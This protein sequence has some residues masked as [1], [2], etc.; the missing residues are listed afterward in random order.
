MAKNENFTDFIIPLRVDDLSFSEI[1]VAIHRLNV[2]DFTHGWASG[3][4]QVLDKLEKDKVP[5]DT[6]RFNPTAVSQWWKAHCNGDDILRREPDRYLSNWFPILECPNVVYVHDLGHKHQRFER[7]HNDLL[8]P[9]YPIRDS[10]VSFATA[11]D[12][13]LTDAKTTFIP[14]EE[15]LNPVNSA[16][17]L[18]ARERQNAVTCLM[19]MAWLAWIRG[20][21]PVHSMSSDRVC[22]Y[23][24]LEKVGTQLLPFDIPDCMKGRRGLIG[25]VKGK[26]WHFGISGDF[27]LGPILAMVVR[28]HVLF[29]SDGR[30]IWPSPQALHRKRRSACKSWWNQ[31]WRDRILASMYW[32]SQKQGGAF[33]SIPLSRTSCLQVGI[34]PVSFESPVAYDDVRVMENP[35][36][37]E[38]SVDDHDED[39]E[40]A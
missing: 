35:F 18:D 21:L 32:L 24:T 28:P 40:E 16:F 2:I 15:C 6:S 37:D 9:G 34:A 12:L 3:L 26:A 25:E 5:Q 23:F 38:V 22:A 1:N 7:N 11:D 20:V 4:T 36:I 13:A 29:S 39:G 19:R 33:L 30:N 10:I 8:F 17:P 27:Q 31:H 14:M